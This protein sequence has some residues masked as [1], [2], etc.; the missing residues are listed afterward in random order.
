MRSTALPA[1]LVLVLLSAACGKNEECERARLA[2]ASSWEDVR[3]Q[4]GRFKFQGA[5][6]FENLTTEQKAEH[7]K[8]FSEIEAQAGLV[9]ES[10]A[11]QKITWTAAKNGRERA[12]KAFDD[13]R[14]KDQY[15]SFSTMLQG[16]NKKYDATEAACR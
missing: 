7:H 4:A 9:F 3:K 10:F 1:T 16:A 15:A 13:Y 8:V 2:A 11:F 5:P 12:Q 6:G 14:H